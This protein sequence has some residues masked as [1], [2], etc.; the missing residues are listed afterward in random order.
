[1]KNCRVLL[2]G[3]DIMPYTKCTVVV[4]KLDSTH[5]VKREIG[6]VTREH[7]RKHK[8]EY[9]KKKLDGIKLLKKWVPGTEKSTHPEVMTEAVNYI[10]ELLHKEKG[11]EKKIKQVEKK[12]K[13]LEEKIKELETSQTDTDSAHPLMP[14]DTDSPLIPLEMAV[15]TDTGASDSALMPH[16]SFRDMDTGLISSEMVDGTVVVST[17]M[18]RPVSSEEEKLLLS[19]EE[20]PEFNTVEELSQ[21]LG[22]DSSMEVQT[23]SEEIPESAS[24]EEELPE[25]NSV[26]ALKQWLG[27]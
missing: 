10:K 11:L 3:K 20:L 13:K 4:E 2:D 25:F 17:P 19:L 5:P 6:V 26:E 22:L 27:L 8:N 21:W 14:M 15:S 1:M 12:C 16:R 9:D 7:Q 23:T 24:P 18:E